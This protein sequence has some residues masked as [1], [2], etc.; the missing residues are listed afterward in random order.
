MDF[1]YDL[2]EKLQEQKI[3]YFLV[4]VRSGKSKDTADVFY[5]FENDRSAETLINVL[6]SLDENPKIELNEKKPKRRKNAKSSKK[7]A[8]KKSPP[9]KRGRPPKNDG[10]DKGGTK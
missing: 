3:D 2:T 4:T 8:P 6:K 5:C 1:V 10:K 7:A 9:K